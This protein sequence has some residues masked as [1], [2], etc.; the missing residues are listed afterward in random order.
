M[1]TVD[2]NLQPLGPLRQQPS[3]LAALLVSPSLQASFTLR[4]P[5]ALQGLYQAWLARFLQHHQLLHH[6]GGATVPD[7]VVDDYGQRLATA[8]RQ[9]F[10]SDDW[11]PL[12]RALRRHPGAPLR[13]RLAPTLRAMEQWP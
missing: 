3:E 9:W 8:L 4:P 5:A 6:T 7:S 1:Q 13:L 12:H 11:A 2:L 10:N